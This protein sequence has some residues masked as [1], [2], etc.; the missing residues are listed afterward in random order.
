MQS[1]GDVCVVM[2]GDGQSDPRD[3]SI[4]VDEI[5][6]SDVVFGKRKKIGEAFSRRC[7]S[8]VAFLVR[9]IV[10]ADS[11]KDPCGPKALRRNCLPHLIPFDGMHRFMS[12]LFSHAGLRVREIAVSH[13]PR[14]HGYSKYTISGRALRGLR[15]V[16]R[17]RDT[18]S[19]RVV[20]SEHTYQ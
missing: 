4:L 2:D 10:F 3:I 20:S 13:Y 17:L 5:T 8:R 12:V 11:V 16:I 7:A 15:D 6:D 19:R 18:L 9:V 14:K 1:S